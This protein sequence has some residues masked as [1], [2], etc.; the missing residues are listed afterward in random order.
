MERRELR[1]QSDAAFIEAMSITTTFD[2]EAF[3]ATGAGR[4]APGAGDRKAD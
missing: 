4:V 3:A 2:Q 1:R